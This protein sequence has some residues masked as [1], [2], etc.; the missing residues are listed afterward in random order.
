LTEDEAMRHPRRNEVYRDVGSQ[1]RTPD[2]EQF[3]EIVHTVFERDT[4]LLMC[5]DGLSDVVPSAEVLRIVEEN[6][7]DRQAT[8]RKLIDA[9]NQNSKDNVSAVFIEGED[10][11]ESFGYRMR[12]APA[13]QKPLPGDGYASDIIAAPVREPQVGDD[14]FERKL[15]AWRSRGRTSSTPGP[16]EPENRSVITSDSRVAPKPAN[17]WTW[18]NFVFLA[19]GVVFGLLAA[20]FVPMLMP[21]RQPFIQPD[22][23]PRQL[24]VSSV[25][26]PTISAALELARLGDVIEIPPGE[27]PEQIRLKDGIDLIAQ[28]A[29]EAI[30]KPALLPV[31]SGAAITA[32]GIQ[33]CR[34]VGLSVNGGIEVHNSN[35]DFQRLEISGAKSAGI[36]FSGTSRGLLQGSYIHHNTGA[37]IVVRQKAAPALE[38]NIVLNNGSA[39]IKITSSES[40]PIFGNIIA[41]NAAESIWLT[42]PPDETV[43]AKN[44]FTSGA[45]TAKARR[46][47]II[48]GP[49][50]H[51]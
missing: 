4:A 25:G 12:T 47:R 34:V 33:R 24:V 11:A 46:Y 42:H 40:F 29:R 18:Q 35:V 39:G 19:A 37:G 22:A 9:A 41:D 36:E 5:S 27:Y 28:R 21:V 38:N 3:I 49:E 45:S 26:I 30:I 23:G 1:P 2:D 48:T 43:L 14:D 16:G 20:Q 8:V 13:V 7:G 44:F 10:F 15:A 31:G 50:V 17:F 6:A 51:P 32:Q